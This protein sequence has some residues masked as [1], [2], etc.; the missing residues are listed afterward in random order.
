MTIENNLVKNSGDDGIYL[1]RVKDSVIINNNISTN[2]YGI[3]LY[4]SSNNLIF[5]N[6]LINNYNAY[7]TGTNQWDSGTVGNYYS[8]YTG[9]DSNGDGIGDTPHPIPG[10]SN[11]DRYPLMSPYMTDV[12]P[13][14]SISNLHS[15]PGSTWVKW[16]WTNPSDPDFS[17]TKIYLNSIHQTNTSSNFFN[18]TPSPPTPNTPSAPAQ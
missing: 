7:D 9:T 17:Y 6:N 11:E 18:A 5:H 10:G 4:S 2:V 13:P 8:D 12:K 16:T 14:F 15:F 3:R 1:T